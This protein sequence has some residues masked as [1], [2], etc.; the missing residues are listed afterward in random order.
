MDAMIT[1]DKSER[2][3]KFVTPDGT[4]PILLS[5]FSTTTMDVRILIS[6]LVVL[7]YIASDLLF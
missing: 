5:L 1:S 4:K 2:T 6:R 3:K 7:A